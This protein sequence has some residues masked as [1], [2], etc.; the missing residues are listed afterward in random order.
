MSYCRGDVIE[1]FA[2]FNNIRME[3]LASRDNV[4]LYDEGAFSH[5]LRIF[6]LIYILWILLLEMLIRSK[7]LQVPLRLLVLVMEDK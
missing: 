6:F 3:K 1:K 4:Q 7:I 5:D 2:V